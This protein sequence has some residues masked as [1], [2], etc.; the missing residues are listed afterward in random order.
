MDRP[1]LSIEDLRIGMEISVAQVEDIYV[2]DFYLSD[3][4][5]DAEEIG[6]GILVSINNSPDVSSI[7]DSLYVFKNYDGDSID[8]LLEES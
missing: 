6:I 4:K 3:F 5:D 2:V 8:Y 7:L 1:K